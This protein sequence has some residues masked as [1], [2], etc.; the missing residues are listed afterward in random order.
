MCFFSS[1]FLSTFAAKYIINDMRKAIS[2]L[3]ALLCIVSFV[4]CNDYETYGEKKEKERD[5]INQF[6][7]DSS[8]VV[9]SE[10]QFRSQDS[11]TNVARNEFVYLDNSGVYMQ[12]VHR[13]CGSPIADGEST[14]LL[15]R[16]YEQCLQDT[17][18]SYNDFNA[19]TPDYMTV[20]R[21]GSTYSGTF[22]SGQWYNTYASS[23]SGTASVPNGLL[24]P[25]PYINV[26]RPRSESDEIAKVRLIVPHSQGHATATSYVYAYYYELTFERLIDL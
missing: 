15:V 22:T 17:L 2:S 23:Y 25:F 3:V 11:T 7:A 10:A 6:I 8:I 5:A 19:F 14:V 9:I 16:F 18:F 1:H 13:G 26:G 24:V 12:I 4:A 21:S 20:T